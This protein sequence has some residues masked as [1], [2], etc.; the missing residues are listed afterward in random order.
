MALA[1]EAA[2]LMEL[3]QW[4]TQKESW[5]ANSQIRIELADIFIYL[6]I[7]ADKFEIDLIRAAEEK[8]K[9]NGIKYPI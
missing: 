4:K 3:F 1:V 2:E 7:L 9:L 8:I 6:L 5:Q